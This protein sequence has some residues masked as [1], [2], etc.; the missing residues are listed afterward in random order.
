VAVS[1]APILTA[2]GRSVSVSADLRDA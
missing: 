1:A 2:A